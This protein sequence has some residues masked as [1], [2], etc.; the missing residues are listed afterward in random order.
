MGA[1][2]QKEGKFTKLL[3]IVLNRHYSTTLA[4]CPTTL[5]VPPR[6]HSM[7]SNSTLDREINQLLHTLMRTNFLR[8][9][10]T[11]PPQPE[12]CPPSTFHKTCPRCGP[13]TLRVHLGCKP[14]SLLLLDVVP[15]RP[16]Q[17]VR[18]ITAFVGPHLPIQFCPHTERREYNTHAE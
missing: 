6:N 17:H 3:H 7:K 16:R 9:L 4:P 10:A 12:G 5:P 14:S 13:C 8:A 18:H 2:H 15:Y 11:P 1:C